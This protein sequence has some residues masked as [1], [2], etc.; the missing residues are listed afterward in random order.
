MNLIEAAKRLLQR[1]GRRERR[2]PVQGRAELEQFFRMLAETREIELICDDIY[3]I[4][5]QYAELLARGED[6]R[7]LMP[8]VAYHLEMC[9]DCHEEL[10]ALMRILQ[11]SPA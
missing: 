9:K 3:Q 10:E 8:L 2:M 11:A 6:V 4:V 7:Q 1:L 5:D